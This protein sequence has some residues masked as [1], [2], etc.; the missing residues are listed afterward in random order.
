M[1][2]WCLL[3][4]EKRAC[5]FKC[6]IV[7]ILQSINS[8]EH[9]VSVPGCTSLTVISLFKIQ[10]TFLWALQY[11]ELYCIAFNLLDQARGS[12]EQINMPVNYV[13][14]V[15]NLVCTDSE[16]LWGPILIDCLFLPLSSSL[17]LQNLG[18]QLMPFLWLFAEQ[19][20]LK[21]RWAWKQSTSH[22]VIL[23]H[24]TFKKLNHS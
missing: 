17:Y 7:Y 1:V 13:C 21:K 18:G 5:S 3:E 11:I 24:W 22:T 16:N 10:H 9:S 20:D 15:N 2:C 19:S 4:L 23:L 14:R 12:L 8:L 6:A